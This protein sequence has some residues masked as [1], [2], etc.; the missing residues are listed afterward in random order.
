MFSVCKALDYAHKMGVVHRDVKPSNIMLNSAGGAKITD[1]GIAHIETDSSPQKG[2]VGS[3]SYMSPEQVREQQVEE[4]SDIFSLGCVLYELLVGER[5]FTGDNYFSVLY[6]ITHED[7]EPLSGVRQEVPEVFDRIVRKAISKDPGKRYQ[8]CMDFAYELRVALRRLKGTIRQAKMEDVLDYVHHVPFFEKFTRDQVKEILKTSNLIKV[9]KGKV[10][11]SEGEIDDSFFVI[12]SGK[13]AVRKND[14]TLASIKRGECFGE[15]SYL[16]GQSRAATVV[17]AADSILMKISA[18][19]LD[20][21]P[22]SMQL[23]F[24]RQFAETLLGRLAKSNQ[25]KF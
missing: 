13:A 19:L 25:Q 23:L 5:A 20:R 17:A 9:S 18:T 8:T 3:P 15:M 7:P 10:I 16:S 11:V 6:K 21:A 22:E 14:Q 1:F 24:L 2:I 4:T 12:L